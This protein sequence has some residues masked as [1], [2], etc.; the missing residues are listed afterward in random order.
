MSKPTTL[1]EVEVKIQQ[2]GVLHARLQL[3][4]RGYNADEVEAMSDEDI[5]ATAD[6]LIEAES[7]S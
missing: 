7:R 1:T 5:V 6:A 4:F 3:L 2:I